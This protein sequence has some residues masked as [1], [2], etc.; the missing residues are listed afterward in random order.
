[1]TGLGKDEDISLQ[2]S[3]TFFKL[4]ADLGDSESLYYRSFFEFYKLDGHY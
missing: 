2:K 4:A 1:M 3:L